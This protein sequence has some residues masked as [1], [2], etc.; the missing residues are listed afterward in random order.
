MNIPELIEA[1]R[2]HRVR[3]PAGVL[4]IDEVLV[5]W[6]SVLFFGRDF[7]LKVR[8]PSDI[9]GENASGIGARIA[10][11]ERE[12]YI[13]ARLSPKTYLAPVVL[14]SD[15]EGGDVLLREG[16]AGGE[17]VVAMYRLDA[18]QRLDSVLRDPAVGPERLETLMLQLYEFH[19][20]SPLERMQREAGRRGRALERWREAVGLLRAGL[21][22]APPDV[23]VA[24]IGANLDALAAFGDE[25]FEAATD[26]F[27]HRVAEGRMRN[28]HGALQLTHIFVPPGGQKARL[29][30]P[31]EGSDEERYL[32][33]SEELGG[34]VLEMRLLRPR[35]FI[36]RALAPYAE[37]AQD[38]T[39][40]R[41]LDMQAMQVAVRRAARSLREAAV[42]GIGSPARA[43]AV[44]YMDLARRIGDELSNLPLETAKV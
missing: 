44:V 35:S 16:V 9:D 20:S 42:E 10:M 38:K 19:A 40:W 26:L 29:I 36:E 34:L 5:T 7:V 30:D 33:T 8:R 3:G 21:E 39:L 12:R 1:F 25:R 27:A 32:D 11:A 6:K 2:A 43:R 37:R 15:G 23:D 17:P 41:V 4:D 14:E 13:G 18:A 28:V 24:A 22:A 31:A